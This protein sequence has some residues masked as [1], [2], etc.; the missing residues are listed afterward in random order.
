[1]RGYPFACLGALALS[2]GVGVAGAHAASYK[3]F[4]SSSC[5]Y[6]IEYP[7]GWKLQ[8]GTNS[9]T[10]STQR[11]SSSYAAVV[12]ACTHSR[13]RP[14]T[15]GLTVAQMKEFRSRGYILSKVSYT[16]GL[17]IFTGRKP[18][19]AGGK[20]FQALI[21]ISSTVSRNRGFVFAFAADL[22][23]FQADLKLYIHMLSSWRSS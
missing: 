20:T 8:R 13:Q 3:R 22:A 11:S 7:S 10:F 14:T 18:T 21:E 9:E 17:G 1:M 15:Q 19:T 4:S 23:S 5:R 16:G 6:S 12:V 2:L